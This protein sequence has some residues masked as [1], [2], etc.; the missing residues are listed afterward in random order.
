MTIKIVKNS[1]T[2]SIDR[3]LREIKDLP[4]EMHDF[5]VKETPKKSGNARRKTK[6][7]GNKII[8]DY[9]Y[10][11]QLDKGS[12]KQAPDGMSDPTEKFLEKR[13]SKILRK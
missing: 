10:A 3:I 1:M 7:S 11:R 13:L 2:P 9:A 8:A 5:W 4:R 12:S 6:L